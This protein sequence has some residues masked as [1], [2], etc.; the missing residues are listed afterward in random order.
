M[1]DLRARQ[2]RDQALRSPRWPSQTQGEMVDQRWVLILRE[3]RGLRLS[4]GAGKPLGYISTTY[5]FRRD[6]LDWIGHPIYLTAGEPIPASL[7]TSI[8]EKR[9]R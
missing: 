9:L 7:V 1:R 8:H 5:I 2:F 6:K 4:D 3:D